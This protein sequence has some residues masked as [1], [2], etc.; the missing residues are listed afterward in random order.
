MILE[1]LNFM[2]MKKR[3]NCGKK[4]EIEDDPRRRLF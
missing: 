4:E 2:N 1:I 3:K